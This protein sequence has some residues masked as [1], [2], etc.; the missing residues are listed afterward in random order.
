MF[1]FSSFELRLGCDNSIQLSCRFNLF[2]QITF[3]GIAGSSYTGDIAI[4]DVTIT[5]GICPG[6]CYPC[7][8]DTSTQSFFYF[9]SYGDGAEHILFPRINYQH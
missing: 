1:F 7:I 6:T 3:E 9:L 5:D 2:I 8:D 4:D